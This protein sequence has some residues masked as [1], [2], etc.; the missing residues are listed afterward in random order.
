VQAQVMRVRDCAR[1][2]VRG[3]VAGYGIDLEVLADGAAI[4]DSF[5]GAPE[6]GISRAGVRC[7]ADTPLHSLLHEL[8]HIMCMTVARRSVLQRNAGG[9]AAEECAVC[10]LQI[11]LADYLP[12]FGA[13]R[14]LRDM[15]AWGYSFRQGSA[16]AW[17]DGDGREAREWL[18]AHD[19]IDT[20]AQP[21]WRLRT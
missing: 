13:A 15:D 9:D 4:E 11:I 20:A 1:D 10:Y 16:Q 7:R 17:F 6:A 18:R 2:D 5:W 21:T 14:C 8:C 3:L 12:G 19:L